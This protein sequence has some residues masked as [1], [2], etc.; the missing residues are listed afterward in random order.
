MG[1]LNPKGVVDMLCTAWADANYIIFATVEP[2]LKLMEAY[3]ML[4][5]VT[6]VVASID[7][8]EKV[9]PPGVGV[10]KIVSSGEDLAYTIY[11]E[12]M[13][14]ASAPAQEVVVEDYLDSDL[15]W[16]SFRLTEISWGGVTVPIPEGA[17]ELETRVTVADYRPAVTKSWWVEVR[18]EVSTLTGRVR[19]TLTMLDPET[20]QPP[21]DALAGFL[22]PNDAS[23]RGEGHVSFIIRSSAPA[24]TQLTNSAQIVFDANAAIQTNQVWNTV[25]VLGANKLYL[26]HI[27]R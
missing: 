16:A 11:F 5:A 18:A 24:G 27:R 14:T 6:Q 7:P 10:Q 8:N 2:S 20:G 17:A 12:N 1:S 13:S 9:G 15:D 26:P 21:E 23:G 3:M 22:P 4:S 19:W 25:G